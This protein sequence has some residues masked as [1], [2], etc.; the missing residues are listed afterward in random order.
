ML[1]AT[2]RNMAEELLPDRDAQATINF[3]ISDSRLHLATAPSPGKRFVVNNN[4]STHYDG[5]LAYSNLVSLQMTT[6]ESGSNSKINITWTKAG[7]KTAE[8]QRIIS[9]ITRLTEVLSSNEVSI[10]DLHSPRLYS[11]LLS[12]LIQKHTQGSM[13]LSTPSNANGGAGA[14]GGSAPSSSGAQDKGKGPDTGGPKPKSSNASIS[15]S[16]KSAPA[17][18]AGLM[19]DSPHAPNAPLPSGAGHDRS[20]SDGQPPA[21]N[22]IMAAYVTVE[23]S[24]DKLSSFA[25]TT[26]GETTVMDSDVTGDTEF[27]DHDMSATM[28][29]I[30]DP[31]WWN[32]R[33]L[34]GWNVNF[35]DDGSNSSSEVRN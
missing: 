17:T 8:S 6:S 15:G 7:Q 21:S 3:D 28:T 20:I 19:H 9:L 5:I 33:L 25:S 10:D 1:Y 16:H 24:G 26:Q 11:R 31:H 2:L 27:E 18:D 22:N 30:Q 32:N 35:A 13:V 34:P 4:S 29:A 14:A 23:P 12:S